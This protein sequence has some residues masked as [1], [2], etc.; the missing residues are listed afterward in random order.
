ML[1][2]VLRYI[3]DICSMYLSFEKREKN[4]LLCIT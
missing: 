2:D 1:E 3:D 4:E